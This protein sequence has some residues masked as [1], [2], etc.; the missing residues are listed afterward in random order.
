MKQMIQKQRGR[1][2]SKNT[3]V[4]TSGIIPLEFQ[5]M[6][7]QKEYWDKKFLYPYALDL[8]PV[9]LIENPP[10]GACLGSMIEGKESPL[11]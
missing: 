4:K 8:A 3:Q 11:P 9:K 1:I 2:K 10:I 7:L 6:N 5:E